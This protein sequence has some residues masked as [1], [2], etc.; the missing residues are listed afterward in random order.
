[1]L[2]CDWCMSCHWCLYVFHICMS[3][4]YVIACT[5]V[6]MYEWT[7]A[8]FCLLILSVCRYL[9]M[10]TCMHVCMN[11]CLVLFVCMAWFVWFCM[12]D[13]A[14]ICIYGFV[15]LMFFVWFCQCDFVCVC[16]CMCVYIILYVCM[17]DHACMF[18]RL[19]EVH[20]FVFVSKQIWV[21]S[22]A[23][24]LHHL[25]AVHRL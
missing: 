6:S 23:Q 7:D 8:W 20:M 4:M 18:A 13:D 9:C 11:V 15:C 2:F 17:H 22:P 10:R 19:Y 12:H 14:Y 25:P 1:M 21:R 3:C 24:S 16:V 5:D